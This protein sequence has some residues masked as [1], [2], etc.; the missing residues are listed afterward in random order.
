MQPSR[1][2]KSAHRA[3]SNLSLKSFAIAHMYDDT[4][5]GRACKAW[6][7]NK[8]S[9]VTASEVSRGR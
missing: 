4:E 2:V 3:G 7:N 1:I 6:L 8:S 9:T 5:L